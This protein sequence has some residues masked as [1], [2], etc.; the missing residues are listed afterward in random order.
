MVTRFRKWEADTLRA[1]VQGNFLA[2]HAHAHAHTH[3]AASSGGIAVSGNQS[4]PR[5]AP[6]SPHACVVDSTDAHPFSSFPMHRGAQNVL[7]NNPSLV[8]LS[9]S[10]PASKPLHTNTSPAIHLPPR[11]QHTGSRH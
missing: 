5:S 9:S 4:Q 11:L 10:V 2:A 8:A 7:Q 6:Q 3:A 1:V